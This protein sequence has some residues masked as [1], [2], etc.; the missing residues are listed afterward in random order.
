MATKR[1]TTVL[2]AEVSGNAELL[3]ALGQVEGQHEISNCIERLRRAGVFS[4]GR[5]VKVTDTDVMMVFETPDGAAAAA[6][7]MHAA[8][9]AFRCPGETKLGVKVGFETGPVVVSRGDRLGDTI[10]LAAKLVHE[11][12]RGETLTSPQT[13]ELLSPSARASLRQIHAI[14]RAREAAG[15][16][17][18]QTPQ[19]HGVGVYMPRATTTLRLQ[20]GGEVRFCSRESEAV[21][22]G[23]GAACALAIDNFFASRRHCTI[24]LRPGG[25]AIRDHSSN[26][27]YLT[28]EGSEELVLRGDEALLAMHGWVAFGQPRHLASAVLEFS[29]L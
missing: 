22:V 12:Q 13:V 17:L 1:L 24:Q 20:Y 11:A 19:Q 26:G 6:A 27:T 16:P 23:R 4:G 9:E 3:S 29:G 18:R 14:P 8:A 10:K 25:F 7:R 15:P 5:V 28:N 21:V 2:L